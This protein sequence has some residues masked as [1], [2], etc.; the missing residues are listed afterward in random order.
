MK[1]RDFFLRAMLAEEYKR[2][3]WVISAFA[4]V[5]ENP[6]AWKENPYPYRIVQ[7]PTNFFF[8]DPE[9]K[10][11][12]GGFKLTPIEDGKSGEPLFRLQEKVK[13]TESEVLLKLPQKEIETT[14]GLVVL[15]YTV[16][17]Y[18]FGKKLTYINNEFRPSTVEKLI[19]G[20][21][22][23]NPDNP[24]DRKDDEIYVDEY[25]RYCDAAFQMTAFAQISVPGI[26]L[27]ALTGAP[28]IVE[29]R[30][31]LLAE[32]KDRL[33]DPAVIAGIDA[34][35]VKYDKDYL[36]DDE[37]KDFLIKDKSFKIVRK[38]LFGMHGAEP[39]FNTNG[40]IDLIDN[41]LDEGWNPNK[42]PVLIN[43]L[44]VGSYNR[45]FETQ[46][47]GE[48]V[49]WLLRA[50]S[51][52]NIVEPDCG[53]KLGIPNLVTNDNLEWFVDHYIVVGD[54]PVLIDTI[55]A[56]KPYIGKTVVTRSPMFCKSPKTD[57][58]PI[59]V[60]RKLAA[61]PEAA[62]MAVAD[63]GSAFL[64]L[65]MAAMHGKEL[66]VAKMDWKTLIF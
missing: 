18:P 30:N 3:E 61:N 22:K 47:G 14:Y 9:N 51:N 50:S 53:T 21:F 59:C 44:R 57:Y 55:D 63:Y 2:V 62:S 65:F 15:N 36:A 17:F 33:T 58:C 11:E 20:R 1:K 28:G 37:S 49:K 66:A 45:G 43:N 19:V 10:D 16:I 35:L 8:V 42:F 13:I 23:D 31:K 48:A 41:S 34:A 40:E 46:L 29:F 6:E 32:N 52:I 38:R 7:T 4:V 60:G 54:K 39:G 5:D 56:I 12:G 64:G 24:E 27:K 26:T 25:L